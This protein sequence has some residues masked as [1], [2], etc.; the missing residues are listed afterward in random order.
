M[1]GTAWA[2]IRQ[3]I[4][5]FIDDEGL[6]RGA[7]IAFYTMFSIVPVLAIIVDVVGVLYGAEATR[8]AVFDQIR[9]V[10]GPDNAGALQDM[11]IASH[12]SPASLP[13]RI[14]T[15]AMLLVTATG[16]FGE[17]QTA[18]NVVW[19]HDTAD[20]I[21]ARPAAAPPPDTPPPATPPPA[22]PWMTALL[23]QR[24][25][26]LG[27]IAA[28]AGLLLVSLT[29]NTALATL[30][31]HIH[32]NFPGQVRLVQALNLSLSFGL[33]MTLFAATFHLL[34]DHELAWRDIWTGAA[35]TALLFMIGETLIGLYIGNLVSAT[36][37]GAAGALI[38][39]MLWIYYSAQIFLLGAEFT[40]AIAARRTGS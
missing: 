3:S 32:W 33:V 9:A 34:P 23:Y 13:A 4:A 21:A 40:R 24:V 7:A 14:A 22:T 1:I 31:G 38:V 19:R 5:N 28:L 36:S 26:A 6:S 29:V 12:R 10:M 30:L 39:V 20:G 37:Y 16:V 27:L 25:L 2:V 15:V 18:L 17:L 11:L 35:I 8:G